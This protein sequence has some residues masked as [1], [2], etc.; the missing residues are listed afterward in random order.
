MGLDAL[1]HDRKADARSAHRTALRP[2]ALVERLEDSLAILGMHAGAVVRHVD[3]ELG[4]LHRGETRS[5][6][7]SA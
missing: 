6:R 5:P 2:P 3:H 1:G 4:A 7:R